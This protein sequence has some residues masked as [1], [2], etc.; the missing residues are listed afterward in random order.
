MDKL[1]ELQISIV[2]EI[3]RFGQC[4]DILMRCAGNL[5]SAE[6]PDPDPDHDLLEGSSQ[7]TC[8][9]YI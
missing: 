3:R 6:T 2:G 9:V 5:Y 1:S 7:H 4:I 8:N